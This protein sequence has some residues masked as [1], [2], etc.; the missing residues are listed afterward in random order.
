MNK[1]IGRKEEINKL[2]KCLKS[3]RSEFVIISGRRRVGKTFLI[4]QLYSD[5]YA[6]YYTGGHNLTNT[7]QLARFSDCLKHYSKSIFNIK[8]KDW[9]DA[10]EQLRNYIDSLPSKS[11]KIIFFDEMP[12]IDSHNSKFVK[13]LEYFW[14]A[15]ASLRNDIML[16]ASG[17]AT[18]WIND[19]LIDN[20]GGL[21]NRITCQIFLEPF[22]LKET[23]EFLEKN[24]FKW[25]RYM[26]LQTYMILGGVP[27]YLTLLN[28]Q[29]SLAQNIDELCFSKN[30]LLK[31]EFDELYNALFS[32]A[33]KYISIVKALSVKDKGLTRNEIIKKTKIQ[34]STL[35]RMLS[36]L[37]KCDFIINYTQYEKSIKDSI[38]RLSD[39]YT[40]FYFNFIQN[41]SKEKNFWSKNINQPSINT[42]Q[43]FSFELI[44]LKHLDQIKKALGLSV[45]STNST[46]CRTK[47][48][49]ID[50]IID[51]ADRIINLCEI[52][53]STDKYTITN[54]YAE[55]LR[56]RMAQFREKIKVKK[57]LVN[58][59]ITTYGIHQN[60]NYS[61]CQSEINMDNLFD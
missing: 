35:T 14:N 50:L 59:F 30:G 36:N 23:E 43:G 33:D 20:Q 3:S 12:W 57:T 54:D 2:N 6:F 48:F 37:E 29:L 53:F 1:L 24:N 38:Y 40:L 17:S 9:F 15:W 47:D 7:E 21:H 27:F 55:K 25:D 49:Q 41:N 42:W 56:T 5:K 26:I 28:N 11:R 60:K 4:N 51:R 32:N 13:A 8:L 45:I 61:I 52:K 18:S 58:T 46:T 16:I 19:K 10:F 44:C 22:N 39:F 31:N 34:G